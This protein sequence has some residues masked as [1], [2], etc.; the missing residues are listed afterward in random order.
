MGDLL[1]GGVKEKVV[2]AYANFEVETVY[3]RRLCRQTTFVERHAHDDES[4]PRPIALDFGKL[5]AGG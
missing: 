2:K 1:R 3:R 5:I 4:R